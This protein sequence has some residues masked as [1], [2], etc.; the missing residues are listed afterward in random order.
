VTGPRRRDWLVIGTATGTIGSFVVSNVAGN[1][2]G[3]ILTATGRLGLVLTTL[4]AIAWLGFRLPGW[5]R[6]WR[7]RG[8]PPPARVPRAL[9]TDA[10][11][12]ERWLVGLGSDTSGMAAAEWFEANEPRLRKLVAKHVG[13]PAAAE[14]LS[15]IGDALDAWYVRRRRPADLLELAER[16]GALANHAQRRD[17]KEVAAARAATAYRLAGDLD[18]ATRELGRSAGL[19]ARGPSAAAVRARREVEWALSNLARAD[20]CAPGTDRAEHLASAHDRLAD[21]AGALPRTDLSGDIAIHLNLGVIALY[22]DEPDTALD[23]L[24]LAAARALT[25]R[26]VSTQAHAHELAGIVAWSQ[27]NPREAAARWQHAE[28]LY[29]EVAERESQARCLQ[30]LG[31][32]ALTNPLVAAETRRPGEPA[33]RVALRLLEASAHLREGAH[34]H[35]L[36]Q[37]YLAQAGRPHP[38]PQPPSTPRRRPPLLQRLRRRLTR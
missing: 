13:D 17:L 36:L 27:D 3:D 31:S 20:G 1:V 2:L 16:L 5:V 32:A 6:R 12:A 38:T 29:A 23:H 10:E 15:K 9:A 37:H 11:Q 21:A 33:D 35:A 30:H 26:D 14:P 28:H 22:R 24:D 25:A 34:D 4:A 18:A 8:N 19:A 7:N